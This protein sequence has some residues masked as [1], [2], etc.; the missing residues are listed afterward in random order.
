M[1]TYNIYYYGEQR[2]DLRTATIVA[3][4]LPSALNIFQQMY[5]N[6]VAVGAEEKES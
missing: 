5:E 1:K 6:C 3:S 4:T 2:S